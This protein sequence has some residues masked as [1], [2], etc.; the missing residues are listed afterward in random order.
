MN[1]PPPNEEKSLQPL[2]VILGPTA[3]G[4]STLGVW[5]AER[6]GGEVVACDSTQLYRGFD[7]GTAKPTIAERRGIPHHLIDVLDATEPSTAGGYRQMALAVLD[8]LRH[9][10]RLPVLTVGTGLYLRALVEGLADL[11]QRSEELRERLRQS[12]ADSPAASLASHSAPPRPAVCGENFLRRRTKTHPRHRN[13]P[14]GQASSVGSPPLGPFPA[15]RLARAENRPQP[16]AR[17]S[18]RTHS[19]PNRS[20]VSRGLARRSPCPALGQR[21]RHCQAVRVH[22][23]PRAPLRPP[24][25][26]EHCKT[27]APPSSNP[28]AATPNAS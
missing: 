8:D 11:P 2:V 18:L 4:K 28:P 19:R 14:A 17:S 5:L 23:L 27:P 9:R 22:R 21:A 10:E 12:R 16:A 15:A 6:L 26:N 13:L 24:R 3:S 1:A 25:R 20:D 7:I